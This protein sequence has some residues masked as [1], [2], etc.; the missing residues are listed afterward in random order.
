MP[1]DKRL[2]A[3]RVAKLTKLY[4][5][6]PEPEWIEAMIE[7]LARFPVTVI[8]AATASHGLPTQCRY[9]PSIAQTVE[10]CRD[11][12]HRQ[13]PPEPKVIPG[14]VRPKPP[15]E[16]TPEQA[17]R[18]EEALRDV[19]GA[20]NRPVLAPN[21][22]L[23]R[24]EFV[25][26]DRLD[27]AGALRWNDA[28]RDG[29]SIEEARDIALCGAVQTATGRMTQTG[30]NDLGPPPPPMTPEAQLDGQRDYN[31]THPVDVGPGLRQV[32]DRMRTDHASDPETTS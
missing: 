11:E 24:S 14:L 25:T 16:H 27:A 28:M 17:A 8:E 4:L 19:R 6:R 29:R 9:L 7:T 21:E 13:A 15:P 26:G 20:I 22:I 18:V 31:A 12:V 5:V 2:V 30:A 10:F 32:L 1:A 23:R 3:G